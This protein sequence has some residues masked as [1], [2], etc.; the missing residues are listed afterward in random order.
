MD[1]WDGCEFGKAE[2]Q[3]TSDFVGLIERDQ[4]VIFDAPRCSKMLRRQELA[5]MGDMVEL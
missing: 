5:Y 1:K 3:L 2:R 4:A